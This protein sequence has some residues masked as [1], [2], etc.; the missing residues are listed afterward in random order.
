M[1]EY[2]NY[3]TKYE[4]QMSRVKDL[5]FI[6]EYFE[7]LEEVDM[8]LVNICKTIEEEINMKL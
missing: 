3:K 5:P 6:E 7:L 1:D 4:L 8:V 2:K